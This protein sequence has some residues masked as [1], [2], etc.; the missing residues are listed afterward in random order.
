MLTPK[1]KHALLLADRTKDLR[2]VV[3]AI[4]EVM[5]E[6]PNASYLD[7][8][9]TFRDAA[10]QTYLV[11]NNENKMIILFGISK[12]LETLAELELDAGE[13][14]IRLIRIKELR[15]VT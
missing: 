7:V 8:E 15:H 1:Q 12:W 9:M 3:D 4:N 13:N 10:A 11:V 14:W 2:I 6:N 5:A